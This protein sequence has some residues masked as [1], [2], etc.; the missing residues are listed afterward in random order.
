LSIVQDVNRSF[1]EHPY[2][3]SEQGKQALRNVLIAYSWRNPSLGYCQSM[4]RSCPSSSFSYVTSLILLILVVIFSTPMQNIICSLLLLFMGEEESFWALTILCE[5]L[6]PQYFTPDM[7]GSMT[8]QHVLEDLVAEH[9]PKLNAHLESIQLP[10]V[11]ISFP[12]FMCLFIGYIPMQVRMHR[13]SFE[14][15]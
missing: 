6:F 15:V 4:V 5:E 10:L 1:P 2:F 7:L 12:W 9:F 11:L 14:G 3:Q 8:D 13:V